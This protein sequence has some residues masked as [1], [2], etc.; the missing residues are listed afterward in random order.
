MHGPLAGR[1]AL[2]AVLVSSPPAAAEVYIP[3]LDPVAADGSRS[4]TEL[5]ISNGGTTQA[6]YSALFLP[7][8]S[9]GT[10]RTGQATTGAVVGG[11]SINV[12]KVVQS[13][14]V[15]LVAVELAAGMVLD[16]RIVSTTASGAI[17]IAPVPVIT[18]SNRLAAGAKAELVGLERDPDRG[19]LIHFGLVNLGNQVAQC[20]LAFFRS[21]G[22]SIGGNV[23]LALQP[24]SLSHYVDA[25]STLGQ[26]K[27]AGVRSTVTCN[28]PFYAYAALFATP[29]SHY[30]FIVPAA[31]PGSGGT[32]PPPPPGG[33]TVVFERQGVVHTASVS[34]PKGRVD[35]PVS[36]ELSLRRLVLDMDVVA[37]PWNREKIPGNHAIVWLYR[38]KFRGNT[39]ANINSF[40]PNKYT[41]KSSQNI[42]LP[43]GALTVDEGGL[44]LIQGQRY[45]VHHVYDAEN[46]RVTTTVS[47]G[48]QTKLGLS[49]EATAP[50][51]TL[52]I[53]ANGMVAEF[54]HYFGQEGPEVASPGWSYQNLRIEMT[55]Y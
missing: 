9:D 1:I 35:V 50:N 55:T 41:V 15:G 32:N 37:G 28:Q 49:M 5:W 25:L 44:E 19:R 7:A 34:V 47:T 22:T 39:V 30:S 17:A 54:G 6:Q 13:G 10:K 36:G 16:A 40:G 8:F 23:L 21:D 14:K 20:Q 33:K 4:E 52:V 29:N 51:R 3:A 53:P 42:E 27:I 11:R 43:A 45:H 31:T 2:L 12:T 26:V 48:G 18:A 46:G 24:L 38:G